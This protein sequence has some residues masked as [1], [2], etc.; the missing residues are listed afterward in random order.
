MRSPVSVP[1]PG[2]GAFEERSLRD[3]EPLGVW[4]LLLSRVAEVPLDF[5][6]C[7]RHR[8]LRPRERPSDE[9]GLEERDE[10][11]LQVAGS[12]IEA[13]RDAGSRTRG[14][15]DPTQAEDLRDVGVGIAGVADRVEQLL[16]QVSRGDVHSQ[17]YGPAEDTGR[18]GP[19]E[20]SGGPCRFGGG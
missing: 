18:C 6:W 8:E 7:D 1:D 4:A 14:L 20:R 2:G 11:G 10:P 15:E 17:A 9:E 12:R 16:A 13:E 5:P 3:F 19:P